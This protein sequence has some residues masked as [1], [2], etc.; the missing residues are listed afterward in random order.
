MIS[1]VWHTTAYVPSRC[2]E[3]NVL[4]IVIWPWLRFSCP[5]AAFRGF[6]GRGAGECEKREG[7]GRRGWVVG[8]R[9]LLLIACGVGNLM[10]C[11]GCCTISTW[12][13]NEVD[14]LRGMG[15][16]VGLRWLYGHR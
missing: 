13:K 15:D 7:Q 8:I 12:K 1:L 6:C 10:L 4:S 11:G 16:D 3:L 14:G 5:L 9:Y 2:L